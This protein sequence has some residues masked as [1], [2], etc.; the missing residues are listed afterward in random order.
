MP[1]C[2]MPAG[3]IHSS[4][5]SHIPFFALRLQSDFVGYIQNPHVQRGAPYGAAS[6]AA[7]PQRNARVQPRPD[8]QELGAWCWGVWVAAKLV[9]RMVWCVAC[10][11]TSASWVWPSHV[12]QVSITHP[13]EAARA[14]RARKRAAAG[15]VVLPGRYKRVHIKQQQARALLYMLG[16]WLAGHE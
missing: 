2:S 10:D 15:G 3:L 16:R 14:E 1:A 8:T 12:H 6:R 9:V 5:T 13:A 7:A 4:Q 11:E